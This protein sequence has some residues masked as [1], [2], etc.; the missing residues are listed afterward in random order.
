MLENWFR[1]RCRLTF[2]FTW[3]LVAPAALAAISL[4]YVPIMGPSLSRSVAWSMSFL[5]LFAMWLSLVGHAG[6][7]LLLARVLGTE[8]PS[9]LPIYVFGDAAHIWP[10]ARSSWQ[11]VAVAV[12]GPAFNIL[13]ALLFYFVW[14]L[15]L[16]PFLD[17]S[18]VFISLYNAGVACVNVVPGAPMDGG[19]LTRVFVWRIVGKPAYALRSVMWLGW[20]FVSVTFVWGVVLVV[21]SARFGRETGAA[22]CLGAALLA[23]AIQRS[24]AWDW[25][26]PPVPAHVS[27]RSMVVRI[28]SAAIPVVLMFAVAVSLLPVVNG[29]EAP[30]SAV[31]VEPMIDVEPAYRQPHSG[32]FY[33]TTVVTQ[34]PILLAQ[35][36]YGSLSPVITVVPPEQILPP[37]TSPQQF[38]QQSYRMLEDSE[39][40]AQ[41]VA[42]RRAGYDVQIVGQGIEVLN[43]LPDSHANGRLQPGDVIVA[44]DDERVRTVDELVSRVSG[45]A[46]DEPVRLRIKRGDRELLIHVPLMPAEAP[47]EAPQIGISVRTV[48][49]DVVL[50][51]PVAIQPQKVVG[52]PSAGLMF[53]LTLY[54]LITPDDLTRGW[55]VAGTGT[56]NLDGTVGPIG[57]VEQKVAA[58]ESA[59]AA[60]FLVPPQNYSDALRVARSIEV[61]EVSSVD[62]AIEFLR[63]L[64]PKPVQ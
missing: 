45:A 37:D 11:E 38:M 43:I 31:A 36:I 53:T 62:E 52:G 20:L 15:Q 16:H 6:A 44:L 35:L 30:G 50:P 13:L 34:T 10:A 29:I 40:A 41:I 48:G 26:D 14:D 25:S 8:R 18:A 55:P 33:L 59:G 42:L 21:Q 17:V 27:R 7:H 61:V 46:V 49:T 3:L 19:R 5:L 2:D 60:Y 9:H 58:A 47:D 24:P 1:K 12:A 51:F 64:S 56:I 23:W 4:L 54:N 32:N 22:V 28:V 39:T 57:G 63:S